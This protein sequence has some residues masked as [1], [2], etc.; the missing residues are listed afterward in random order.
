M[1]NICAIQT[2]AEH[3]V[4]LQ[5]ETVLSNF[6]NLWVYVLCWCGG[7]R[8]GL[9]ECKRRMWQGER[10]RWWSV[11]E[12]QVQETT[13]NPSNLII[14][15]KAN[16]C[17]L[18]GQHLLFFPIHSWNFHWLCLLVWQNLYLPLNQLSINFA[19][20]SFTIK[21]R[22]KSISLNSF[23]INFHSNLFKCNDLPFINLQWT[24]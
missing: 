19:T 10:G 1:W 24:F 22:R 8:K 9:R 16:G 13:V 21:P 7:M 11:D 3:N 4:L 2:R 6:Q 15:D 18:K 12:G 20:Y 14:A 5:S 23:T 17:H